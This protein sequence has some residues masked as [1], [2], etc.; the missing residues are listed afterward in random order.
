M[1][2][3]G[4]GREREKSRTH[5]GG[6]LTLH[7][8]L[9]GRALDAGA[10][11]LVRGHADEASA[12]EDPAEPGDVEVPVL[13]VPP[14]ARGQGLAVDFPSVADVVARLGATPQPHR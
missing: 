7:V 1:R 3:T 12:V 4:R 6:K 2:G 8:D 10:G 11:A 13:D 14:G 9:G 5:E